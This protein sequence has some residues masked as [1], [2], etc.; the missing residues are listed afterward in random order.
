MTADERT[1]IEMIA[2]KI[3]TGT[4][5]LALCLA[6]VRYLSRS[7]GMEGLV[8]AAGLLQEA[9]DKT[10]S[11]RAHLNNAINANEET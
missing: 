9:I 11:A 1:A 6:C 7:P 2:R 5:S 4:D 8:G 10:D 3:E